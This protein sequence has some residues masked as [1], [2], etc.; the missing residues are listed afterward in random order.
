MNKIIAATIVIAFI[1]VAGAL[2]Y[3]SSNGV[4]ASKTADSDAD[5]LSD[6]DE[7][8]VYHT[9]QLK[10]DTDG[11]GVNDF[12][13][14]FT[15]GLNPSNAA[16]DRELLANLP[17]VTAKQW[18]PS[19]V[20]FSDEN[21]VNKSL[22]D[23]L[24]KYLADKFEIR[25]IDSTKIEGK[26]FVDGSRVWN[27]SETNVDKAIQPSYYFSHGRNGN[28]IESTI[29]ELTILKLSGYK[30]VS[31]V[32]DGHEWSEALIDGK[33]YVVTY[34]SA[35]LREDGFYGQRVGTPGSTYDPDWYLK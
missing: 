21:Y 1:L 5:G 6:W 2:V 13:E 10:A 17:N 9:D 28:C 4:F 31:V 16:D 25:W 29:A 24:I 7:A 18:D 12:H 23:P 8:N 15:Y 14:I 11:G 30:A 35:Y 19:K 27:S 20:G 22:T 3:F 34:N 26:I 33:V 32:G